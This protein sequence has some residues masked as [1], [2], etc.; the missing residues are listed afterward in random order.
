[1][2]APVV[3]TRHEFAGL[4]SR[5]E[6][7]MVAVAAIV[8]AAVVFAVVRYRRRG[9]ERP[10]GRDE[11]KTVE[12]IYAGLVGVIVVLLVVATFT[13]ESRVDAVAARPKLRI[14]VTAFQWQ[15]RFDYPQSGR[16]VVGSVRQEPTLVVPAHTEIQ[17]TE[18]STDVIH[19]FWIPT[20]R[21][22]RDA[23]PDRTTRFDLVFDHVGTTVGHCAEFCGLRHSDMNFKVRVL[24]PAAFR[25][26][27]GG[28]P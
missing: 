27:L 1:V 6:W 25:A 22:K 12:S 5:Y 7:L 16:S 14:D 17:F 11:A 26:W 18:R 24:S 13:T 23:F 2:P 15:W 9:D 21:F 10:R 3:D 28:Q 19:S 4:F 20:E 8:Y